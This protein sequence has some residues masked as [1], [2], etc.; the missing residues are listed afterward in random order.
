MNGN[1]EAAFIGRVGSDAIEV[2][3]SQAGKPWTSLNVAVGKDD[4]TQWVRVALFGDTAERVAGS[5]AKGD[6]LYVE[7]TLRLNTWTD[8]EG[9]QRTGLSVAAWK[10]E[11][12]GQIGRNKPATP[13]ALPEGEHSASP[14]ARDWQR[15]PATSDELDPLLRCG[16]GYARR[17][18]AAC[19][20]V[21]ATP[22]QGRL[23]HL[24]PDHQGEH[25]P[26]DS[27]HRDH[28]GALASRLLSDGFKEPCAGGRPGREGHG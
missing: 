13:K 24:R 20:K 22:A 6:K 28:D 2:K 15:P 5:I 8:R 9:K 7:G 3:T 19:A 11:K 14:A 21:G 18:H 12:V 27:T 26:G 23:R 4:D 1:I 25:R 16:D 17:R 10:A